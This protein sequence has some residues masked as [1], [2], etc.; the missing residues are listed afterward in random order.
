MLTVR[1]GCRPSCLPVG[2]V[3]L[4][5]L[6][7]APPHSV[8]ALECLEPTAGGSDS[9]CVGGDPLRGKHG[10]VIRLR[11]GGR[12]FSTGYDMTGPIEDEA[13]YSG[14]FVAARHGRSPTW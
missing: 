6:T 1:S 13:N 5:P 12:A 3:L 9:T 14:V 8:F 10:R 4:D 7:R 11:G 2:E